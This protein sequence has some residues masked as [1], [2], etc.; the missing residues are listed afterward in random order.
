MEIEVSNGEIVDKA[1]ILK[2]KS[3]RIDDAAKKEN[4][5]K[6]YDYLLQRAA[7]VGMGADSEL[8]ERLY[9]INAQLWDVEDKLREKEAQQSFDA[10]FVELARSVY[11]LND[12]RSR[13]KKEINLATKSNFIEEKSH[14]SVS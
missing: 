6:E 2:I 3:E 11:R 10:D 9:G 4:V 14:A 13:V 5:K 12:E 1:T 8:F 7:E